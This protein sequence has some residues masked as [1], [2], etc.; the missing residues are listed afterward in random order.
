VQVYL[1]IAEMAVSVEA[2]LA[3]SAV[4]GFL[5]AIFG[6][7][8]GF[9]ATPFLIFMGISPAVA[10]GTQCMQ[11]LSSSF[12]GVL[13]HLSKGNVDMKIGFVM[14]SGGVIGTFVGT[15]IFKLLDQTGQIDFGIA[16][17]YILLLAITG[18]LMMAESISSLLFRRK[19]VS[20]AFNEHKVSNFISKLPYK[21]RFARSK[22]YISALVPMS[23]GFV[24]G[25]LTSLLGI[26]G[27]FVMVPAMIYILGMPGLLVTGTSLFQ[28]IF[29]ASFSLV[30][31]AVANH[32]VDLILG[33]IL[34]AGSVVGAQIGVTASRWIKGVLARICLAAIMLTL[35]FFLVMQLYVQPGELYSTVV[36]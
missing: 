31:H 22:L 11:L 14:M 30:L 12:T 26:G 20:A 28:I 2:L 27:G 36:W 8:G 29:T 10:V 23:I 16:I 25:I 32:T 6:I 13:G 4:A 18:G 15:F 19:S 34:I 9:L 35:C 33:V 1:P 24:G 21:M 3:L 5:S 7:G 17:L